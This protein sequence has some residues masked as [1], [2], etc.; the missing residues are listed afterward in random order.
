MKIAIVVSHPIQ[1]LSPLF[2]EISSR[3]ELT[4][5]YGHRATPADHARSGFGVGFDWDV[6]LLGGYRYGFLNN[7]S[8]DPRLER[9]GGV[10]TPDV[11]DRLHD[12]KVDVLM[13]TGWHLKCYFQALLAARRLGIP[14]LVRSDSHLDTPRSRWKL[15]IK[16]ATYPFFLRIFDVAVVVGERSREYWEHYG[17]PSSRIFVAPHCVDREWFRSRAGADERERVRR[18]LGIASTSLVA[19]FSGKLLEVKR[20]ADLIAAA[21]RLRAHGLPVEVVIA[22]SGPLEG[23]LRAL[24]TRVEVPLHLLGFLNQAE[25][26]RAYAASDVLVLP[27]ESETWG[28]VVN[29]ALASNRPVIVSDRTGCAPEIASLFGRRAMFPVSDVGALADRL[30][31]TFVAP[32]GKEVINRACATFSVSRAAEGIIEAARHALQVRRMR[33]Q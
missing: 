15:A 3:V 4:V 32:P 16:N 30:E 18:N 7:V 31:A 11:F 24:S 27:S 13:V 12:E 9:F 21:A 22:G 5:L 26:P 20:P 1:Y 33:S 28:I 29:E 17:Y 2:R 14:T 10:D 23:G 8:S 6:D 25:I 19:M